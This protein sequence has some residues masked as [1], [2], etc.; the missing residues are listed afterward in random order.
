MK[1]E[2]VLLS[3]YC[4]FALLF[5]VN[6]WAENFL[7]IATFSRK[8]LANTFGSVKFNKIIHKECW[9]V[10]TLVFVKYDDLSGLLITKGV[11]NFK[12]CKMRKCVHPLAENVISYCGEKVFT[13]HV[14]CRLSLHARRGDEKLLRCS[15]SSI[16][17]Y[18]F[19]LRPVSP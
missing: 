8:R 11:W 6:K 2:C 4:D 5:N 9:K 12:L 14:V 1:Y 13:V 7:R 15:F 18:P 16:L 3:L 10:E 19:F 17:G